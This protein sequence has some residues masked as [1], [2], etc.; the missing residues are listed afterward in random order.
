VETQT[1]PDPFPNKVTWKAPTY[2]RKA[3]TPLNGNPSRIKKKQV[4]MANIV[5][6]TGR[7]GVRKNPRN[8]K[9][10]KAKTGTQ[11]EL[12]AFGPKKH[13]LQGKV[14]GKGKKPSVK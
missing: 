2:P 5:I 12:P 6:N 1:A 7:S 8:E 13:R 9:I 4:V 11:P 3:E 14:R 10:A